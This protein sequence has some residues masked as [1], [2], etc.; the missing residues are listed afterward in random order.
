MSVMVDEVV[1][2]RLL[3][4]SAGVLVRVLDEHRQLPVLTWTVSPR[5]LIGHV[6][7]CEVDAGRGRRVFTAWA[8]ALPV[9]EGHD[10]APMLD[11]SGVTWLRAVRWCS[12]VPVVLTAAVHPF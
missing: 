9:G 10:P 12:G 7:L 1:Q 4:C 11:E 6:E 5:A 2:R 8:D 3:R